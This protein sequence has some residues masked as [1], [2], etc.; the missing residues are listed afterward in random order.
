MSNEGRENPESEFWRSVAA[1]FLEIEFK[2][3]FYFLFLF[4]AYMYRILL[5]EIQLQSVENQEMIG[6]L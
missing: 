5:Y 6:C 2:M 1:S 3:V 4:I